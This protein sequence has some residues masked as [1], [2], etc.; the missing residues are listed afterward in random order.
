MKD[1]FLATL[2]H[3]LRTPL[4][5]IVGWAQILRSG[6]VDPHDLEEGLAAIERN[7]RV[8]SQL[9]ED[10][11]DISRVNAGNLRLDVQR[12][13]IAEVIEAALAAV[14]PAAT[15]KG[16]RIH[17]V[18]DS[19]AG[20]VTGDF[21]RLQQVVWNLL[22]NAVKFTPK[23]GQVQ[24]LLERVNSHVEISVIDTGRGIRP[25][26]LQHV[27]DRFRQADAS[28]T[29]QYSGL[30]LGLAIAKQLVEMHGG[31]IRAKSPG[32]GQGATFTVTLPI[33]VV[34]PER[35]EAERVR[36]K[37]SVATEEI[38]L[39]DALAGLKVLVVDD[40]PDARQL[41]RRVLE[42]CEAQVA[43]ATSAAE[44]LE[45][46]VPFCP[47]VILSD[48]GMP[49]QDGYD[50]IREVRVNYSAKQIPAAALTAF[51]RTE[52]R[53]RALLAGFQ[54]HIAKP[55]DPA[56]LTAAV[57]SLACRTGTSGQHKEGSHDDHTAPNPRRR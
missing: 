38:S 39:E 47:D 32:E 19:L 4:N 17:K 30:G 11:L 55:V 23:G 5:A 25:E 46:L 40:E 3:E 43:L 16:I 12:L 53:K 44:A 14:M 35:P 33:I 27:F 7:A 21:A 6:K 45:L 56:E 52:D 15:A 54:T 37:E 51:A 28:T 1:E 29:R 42:D 20:P 48:I 13:K 22:S 9:V 2:S 8:Q 10:L 24:V 49:E 26:F 36:P 41:I 31:S 50:L 57:A 34:H 18:L